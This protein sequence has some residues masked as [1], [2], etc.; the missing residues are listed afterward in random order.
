[1]KKLIFLVAFA[2]F[3]SFIVKAQDNTVYETKSLIIKSVSKNSFVH[4]SF[5]QTQDFGYVA[6]NGMIAISNGEAIVFDTPTND[7]ASFELIKAI[8][9]KLKCK[10]VGVVVNHFH[11]DCLGGLKAFHEKK[12]PSYASNKTIELAKNASVEVPQ[13]GFEKQAELKV[14]KKKIINEYFGE[15]HTK[16]NIISYFPSEKVMFGGCMIKEVNAT[17]GY[18]GD[19][20]VAEWSN[21]VQRVKNK[22][23]DLKVVIPGH[24]KYGGT[25]LFDYTIK[26]FKPSN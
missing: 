5:L 25:E 17:K 21:T 22:Y 12:I 6:C 19:A 14:G 1:M 3:S 20:N 7:A 18:L 16:D 13:N 15:G 4:I 9:E 10:V 8:E 26:L 2:I 23:S 24:G 11:N